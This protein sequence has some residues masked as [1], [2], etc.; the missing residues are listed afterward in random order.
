MNSVHRFDSARDPLAELQAVLVWVS[1]RN[2]AIKGRSNPVKTAKGTRIETVLAL[3]EADSLIVSHDPASGAENP[4]FPQELQPRDRSRDSSQQWVQKVAANL[5][6]DSLGRTSR[7]DTGAP[8]IGPDHVV[9]SGNGRSMAIKLAYQRGNA[10]D[11]RQWLI[12]EAD[13]FGLK[14]EQVEAMNQPVLVR[15][16]TSDVDRKAFAVEANQD[17]KLSFT[18]TERAKSDAK[19]LNDH[20]IGLFAPSEDGDFTAAS[21]QRFLQAFLQSL[22][23]AEAA[24]YLTKDGKPTASL[25]HRIRSAVFSKAYNDDR[26][27]EMAADQSKP[28]I[29]NVLNALSSAA[30]RFIEAQGFSRTST[31]E[32]ASGM[33]DSIEQSLNQKVVDTIIK[34]TNTLMASRASNQ[35]IAEYVKQQGLFEDLPEGVPELAVFLAR[36]GRSAKKMGIAFK[37][38]ADFVRDTTIQQ[39]NASL[40]DESEP[41]KM[42]DVVAAANA[43]I[44]REYGPEE[45]GTIGLFD[46]AIPHPLHTL[47]SILTWAKS[48]S[49]SPKNLES[50]QPFM[51]RGLKIY[52]CRLKSG[53]YWAVQTYDNA[54]REARG[55]RQIGGD[56]LYSSREEAILA[57]DREADDWEDRKRLQQKQNEAEK[58]KREAM[59][60]RKKAVKGLTLSQIK[61][62]DYLNEMV[63]YQG[64][65][66]T[67]RSYV[68]MLVSEGNEPNTFEESVIKPMS[69]RQFSRANAAEQRVHE[70]K[71]KRAGMKTVY[72]IGDYIVAKI[73]YEYAVEFSQRGG[74]E[75]LDSV[76]EGICEWSVKS[77]APVL[78]GEERQSCFVV[79][80]DD[81]VELSRFQYEE[82]AKHV[83]DLLN[84]VEPV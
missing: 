53:S 84:Q 65:P 42:T 8:I 62:Y 47:K 66:M 26:L 35:D 51:H 24:Q 76:T 13:Y 9:E 23:E 67:R 41:P 36:S 70:Q 56:S 15:L 80:R 14:P 34:A 48:T 45:G 30:P 50:Q 22:G 61:K 63:S 3:I 2:A 19:R 68:E 44:E 12:H 72:C 71:M 6:P 49:T 73:L 32:V 31:E 69:N 74:G 58:A 78:G 60:A 28:E 64:R 59:L 55:E 83:C 54:E 1:H 16:R 77:V 37:A 52:V 11:Y 43:A 10:D 75:M 25:I 82:D 39:R 81:G 21:N 38:M 27:L 79:V 17:D 33:V 4:A 18:A 5:D 57:A 46:S 20:L 7:A 40:F 29:Q